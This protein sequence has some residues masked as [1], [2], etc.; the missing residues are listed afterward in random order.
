M[1]PFPDGSGHGCG[2]AG[3]ASAPALFLPVVLPLIFF[4]LQPCSCF[5]SSFPN[6][7]E[8]LTAAAA[9]SPEPMR[10]IQEHLGGLWGRDALP[11]SRT[12][13]SVPPARH[14]PGAPAQESLV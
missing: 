7:F 4:L 6:Y 13:R 8:L 5:S 10:W 9:V 11:A 2:G 12:S 3:A 1:T 14:D